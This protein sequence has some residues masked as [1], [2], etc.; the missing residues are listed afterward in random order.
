MRGGEV[1]INLVKVIIR[2][3]EKIEEHIYEMATVRSSV[4]DDYRTASVLDLDLPC[5]GCCFGTNIL[6]H[7]IADRFCYNKSFDEV[8]QKFGLKAI[9][10]N[11]AY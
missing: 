10:D 5:P 2:Y 1:D 8:I 4:A 9:V 7:V 6:T 3:P 11:E